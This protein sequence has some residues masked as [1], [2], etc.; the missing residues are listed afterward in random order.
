MKKNII[1]IC[2]ALAAAVSLTSCQKEPALN[3]ESI[4][5]V[6]AHTKNAFDK[7]L[8]ANYV[9]PYNIQVKY[10]FEMDEADYSY[11]TIPAN[12]DCSIILAHLVK[13]M[14]IDSYDEVAGAAFTRR[15]FPKM[16]F[17]IGEWEYKN[18]GT[19]IL[20]TAEGGKKINLT[21]VNYLKKVLEGKMSGHTDPA[22]ALNH[23]YVKT[24]HHEFT[25]I[26]NQTQDFPADFSQVT[27]TSYVNDAWNTDEYK[28]NLERG[29][30]TAYAQNSDREDF[31]EM[32]S[33]FI[34]HDAQWWEAQMEKAGDSG[35]ASIT[36]KLDIVKSYFKTAFEID[37]EELRSVILRRQEEVVSG[38][39]DLESLEIL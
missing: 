25:H 37:L 9:N 34:T 36:T 26:L 30:I 15:Y 16:F 18:N 10:R 2:M 29:F 17:Y 21:G 27:P 35:K 8:D 6:P 22:E 39:I 13:Y 31:A 1:S 12:M 38:E 5:A 4:I 24:I 7:W 32:T 20:G 14:C 3:P 28:N 19:F 23:Y 33:V 11:Y